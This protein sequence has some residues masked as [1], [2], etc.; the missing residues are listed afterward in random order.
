MTRSL[1]TY[2]FAKSQR[3]A[4]GRRLQPH[5]AISERSKTH[6]S[7]SP[8]QNTDQDLHR[9]DAYGQ[10]ILESEQPIRVR[11]ISQC[12]EQKRSRCD[13]QPDNGEVLEMPSVRVITG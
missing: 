13:Q 2:G 7:D 8:V 3:S 10:G 4:S 1:L 11:H 12:A 9:R 5:L 6:G